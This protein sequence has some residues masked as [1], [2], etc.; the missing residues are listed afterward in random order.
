MTH[1]STEFEI[2]LDKYGQPDVDYYI[3]EAKRL[4]ALALQQIM[5]DTAKWLRSH[6]GRLRLHRGMLH[7]SH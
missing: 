7:L 6:S 5:R 1:N 3:Q 4:R 2:R